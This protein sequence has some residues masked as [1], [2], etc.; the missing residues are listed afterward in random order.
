MKGQCFC[1]IIEGRKKVDMFSNTLI[2][3]RIPTQSLS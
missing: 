1:R 2:N 3:S